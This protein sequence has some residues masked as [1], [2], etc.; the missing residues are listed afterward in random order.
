MEYN[1]AR[2]AYECFWLLSG[3]STENANIC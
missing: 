1:R 3:V 2:N